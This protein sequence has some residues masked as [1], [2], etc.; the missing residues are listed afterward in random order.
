[1]KQFLSGLALIVLMATVVDCQYGNA[2]TKWPNKKQDFY[3][4]DIFY[5]EWQCT[6]EADASI[7]K[8][9][10]IPNLISMDCRDYCFSQDEKKRCSHVEWMPDRDSRDFYTRGSCLVYFGSSN[11]KSMQAKYLL[12]TRGR[13]L[14]GFFKDRSCQTP[15][16]QTKPKDSAC[17]KL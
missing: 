12:Q 7:K 2:V 14:C 9:E 8:Q 5:W 17:P 3:G 1:M 13:A 6:F 16:S 4:K 11:S 15:D 10:T